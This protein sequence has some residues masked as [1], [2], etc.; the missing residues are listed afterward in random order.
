MSQRS[1]PSLVQ[2]GNQHTSG[3]THRLGGVVILMLGAIGI[4]GDLLQKDRNQRRS[5]FQE[6]FIGIS[7][8]RRQRIEPFI[9]GTMVIELALLFLSR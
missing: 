2:R 5:R 8:Q 9:R 6:R 7:T 1:Q 4:N 3:N